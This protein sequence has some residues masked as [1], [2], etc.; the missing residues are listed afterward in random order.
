MIAIC[1]RPNLPV[2]FR[3]FVA[4]I[5]ADVTTAERAYFGRIYA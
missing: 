3:V 5:D 1:P 2:P 4:A